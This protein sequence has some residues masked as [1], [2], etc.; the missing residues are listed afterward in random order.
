MAQNMVDAAVDIGFTNSQRANATNGGNSTGLAIA[1]DYVSP[2]V[3]RAALNTYD[4]FTYTTSVLDM[5]SV[6]DMVYALR[7]CA[8]PKTIADYMVAQT[9]RVS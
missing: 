3:L 2:N 9:K 7:S 8:D 4:S 5:M 6:N 1:G